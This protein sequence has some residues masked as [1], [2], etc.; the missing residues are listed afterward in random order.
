MNQMSN[1]SET[2]FSLTKARAHF[3]K[4]FIKL[5]KGA[6]DWEFILIYPLVHLFSMGFLSVFVSGGAGATENHSLIYMFVGAFAWNFYVLAQKGITY[7]LLYEIWSDSIKHLVTSSAS[8]TEFIV[9]NGAYGLFSATLALVTMTITAI[10]V[11]HFNILAAG[12]ILALGLF[13]LFLYGIAEGMVV[14]SIMLLKGPE[15]M[16][17]TWIITGIVM[18]LSAVYYPLSLIPEPIRSISLLL[19]PTHAIEAIRQAILGGDAL[20]PALTSIALGLIYVAVTA[21][22]FKKSLD[23]S[24]KNGVIL[25]L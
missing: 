13:G 9:G 4:H 16:S 25:R 20:T 24:R 17:L 22:I 10:L 23:K 3:Y 7:G 2:T 18:V 11:F 6:G 8:I 21:L 15:Y 14:N 1:N 19:P 12:P 5:F